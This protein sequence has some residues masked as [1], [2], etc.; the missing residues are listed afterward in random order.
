[1]IIFIELGL[2]L[3]FH[4][5]W[6]ILTSH[7]TPEKFVT[8]GHNGKKRDRTQKKKVCKGPGPDVQLKGIEIGVFL[9]P[10]NLYRLHSLCLSLQ[11]NIRI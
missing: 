2:R 1:M 4:L 3:P 7:V 9:D 11:K 8:L 5:N 10:L 6:H